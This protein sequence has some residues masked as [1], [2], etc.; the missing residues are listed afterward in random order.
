[1]KFSLRGAIGAM[2][3][4]M[5]TLIAIHGWFNEHDLSEVGVHHQI[6]IWWGSLMALFGAGM[7]GLGRSKNRARRNAS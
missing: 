1:M 4:L 5:G 6:S 2:F 3:L 7:I